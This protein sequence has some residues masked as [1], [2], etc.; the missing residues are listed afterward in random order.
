MTGN[1]TTTKKVAGVVGVCAVLLAGV[2]CTSTIDGEAAFAGG[3]G[4]TTSET[5]TS[6]TTTSETTTS[7]TTTSETTTSETTTNGGEDTP[8]AAPDQPYMYEDGTSVKLDAPIVDDEMSGLL[9]SEYGRIL[10]FHVQN[11]SEWDLDLSYTTSDA[12]VNCDGSS[13]WVFSSTSTK[14]FGE[15]ELLAPGESG[16]YQ[17]YVGFR[18]SDVGKTCIIEIPFEAVGASGTDVATFSMVMD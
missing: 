12:D 9:S 16:S 5:T 8:A 2:A 14:P 17:L 4:G 11:N 13:Q 6:E 18:K 1:L 3:G 10:P 15:P 7:E